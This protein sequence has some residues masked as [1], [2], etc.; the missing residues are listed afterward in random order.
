MI[1]I[2]KQVSLPFPFSFSDRCTNAEQ[3]SEQ[4]MLTS[5]R[6]RDEPS[7]L[8]C[9]DLERNGGPGGKRTTRT[10]RLI[11]LDAALLIAG[12]SLILLCL[13]A[14]DATSLWETKKHQSSTFDLAQDDG[15]GEQ[16][17][18]RVFGLVWARAW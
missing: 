3:E 7:K 2:S 14:M 8:P 13:Y 10:Q 12:V 1:S 17:L 4:A 9:V 15:L 6:R 11:V 18:F 16:I 5:R